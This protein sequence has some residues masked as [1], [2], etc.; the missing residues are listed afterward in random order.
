MKNTSSAAMAPCGSVRTVKPYVPGS[1]RIKLLG[2]YQ[3]TIA[4]FQSDDF[5]LII[6]L[7]VNAFA[8]RTGFLDGLKFVYRSS[9]SY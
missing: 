4:A 6:Q 5:F 2:F 3:I 1:I 7:F 9:S 8:D